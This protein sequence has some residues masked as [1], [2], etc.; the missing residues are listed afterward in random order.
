[1]ELNYLRD[2]FSDDFMQDCGWTVDEYGRVKQKGIQ[3]YKP[4]Y[5]NAIDKILKGV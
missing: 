4:G 5:V 3:I 2:A 1:M